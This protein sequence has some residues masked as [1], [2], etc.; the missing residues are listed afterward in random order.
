MRLA[1]GRLAVGLGCRGPHL[2]DRE[3]SP[4][5]WSWPTTTQGG[6]GIG[7]QRLA[8]GA[9]HDDV[10][11]QSALTSER[12]KADK[13]QGE[14]K[15][16]MASDPYLGRSS[17][18]VRLGQR[19]RASGTNATETPGEAVMGFQRGA[20]VGPSVAGGHGGAPARRGRFSRRARVG[21]LGVV[22][23]WRWP[24]GRER[25]V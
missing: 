7:R 3:Q 13:N 8:G 21:E 12:A 17:A 4:F 14:R 11:P 10:I 19:W 15:R 24:S 22:C 1:W 6:E 20:V 18:E 9:Q 16:K 5:R 25:G 2:P 23:E